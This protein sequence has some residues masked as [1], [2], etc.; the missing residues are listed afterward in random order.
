MEKNVLC[1]LLTVLIDCVLVDILAPCMRQPVFGRS[2][3]ADNIHY[4]GRLTLKVLIKVFSED[5][6]CVIYRSFLAVQ[7]WRQILGSCKL[8]GKKPLM[9]F[10]DAVQWWNRFGMVTVVCLS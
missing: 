2:L 10:C 9:V 4:T 5:C 8:M 7:M 3:Q 6:V 1:C